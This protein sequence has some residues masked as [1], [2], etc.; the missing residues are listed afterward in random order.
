MVQR[1]Y[2]IEPRR[3]PCRVERGDNTLARFTSI[4]S[5]DIMKSLLFLFAH[6][7]TP[8]GESAQF[9]TKATLAEN[10]LIGFG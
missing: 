8:P 3:A 1:R 6:F 7:K 2:R 10:R 4:R 5:V 9:D